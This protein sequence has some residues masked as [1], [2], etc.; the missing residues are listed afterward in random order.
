MLGSI[1]AHTS[2]TSPTSN[3]GAPQRPEIRS[4][5]GSN[6]RQRD[7]EKSTSMH[8][9]TTA[10][11]MAAICFVLGGEPA[12]AQVVLDMTMLTCSQFLKSD[13]DRQDIV[14]GWMSGYFNSARNV[15]VL[16]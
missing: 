2:G 13:R 6:A 4:C 15:S 16:N 7:K 14:A 9:I 5:K 1:S 11:S 3:N 8:Q 12:R 10:V